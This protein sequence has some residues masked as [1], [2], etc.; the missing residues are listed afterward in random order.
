MRHMLGT[1]L[2]AALLTGCGTGKDAPPS[3]VAGKAPV[4][5][6]GAAKIAE[7]AYIYGFPMIAA[8]KALY[9]FV[10]DSGGPEYKG[11]FNTI[12]NEHRVFTPADKAI[13]TPNSDT[14]YSMVSMDLRAEPLVLCVP[15]VDPKRYYS[16]QLTDMYAFN[17]GYIGS[18]ATGSKAGCYLVAGPGWSGDT[19]AGISKVFSLETQFGLAIYR[20]QLFNAADMPNVVK[21]QQGY[22]VQPL[23]AFL[24]QPAPPAAPKIDFPKFTEAAFKTDFPAYLNFLLQFAPVVPAEDSIRARFATIGIAPGKPFVFDSLGDSSKA[25]IVAGA[26]AGFKAIEGRRDSLGKLVNGWRVGAAFGNRA[27]YNGDFTLRAAAAMAGIYGNDEAEAM[28]PMIKGLD[29]ATDSFTLTFAPGQLPPVNAFWS[30]TM[31][32][33]KTQLLVDNPINRYLINSTMLPS[34]KKGTDGS[35]TLYIQKRSPGKARESNWLPTPSGPIY[36]VMRLYW[37]KD[38]ALSGAWSPP[39]IVAVK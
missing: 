15:A 30:V 32:D 18:R 36:M 11:P 25:A 13:V 33:G 1:A 39:E 38:E 26:T 35:M 31:Y 24:K 23:S 37:P 14:P 29:A 3:E 7:E 2:A 17:E 9:A 21:V 19:P 10:V 8:Y 34:I 6:S 22:T 20:T 12:S 4:A 28:Y 16:V 27:F 5:S